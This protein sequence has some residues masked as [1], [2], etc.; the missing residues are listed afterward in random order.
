[1]GIPQ[2]GESLCGFGRSP[3]LADSGLSGL[4]L[5]VSVSAEGP[6][7]SASLASKQFA[8]LA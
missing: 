3:H 4:T 1:M 5:L 6:E 7:L 8:F 2:P